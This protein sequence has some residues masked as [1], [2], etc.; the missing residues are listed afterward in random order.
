MRLIPDDI[1]AEVLAPR[2]QSHLSP[3]DLAIR[4]T[5]V[6]AFVVAVLD[7]R[8]ARP[9]RDVIDRLVERL[10]QATAGVLRD[11]VSLQSRIRF[12]S[13]KYQPPSIL[14]KVSR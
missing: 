13:A 4:L 7:K 3:F 2:G 5:R 11:R 1:A 12:R 14:A 6:R 8:A 9:S 10:H